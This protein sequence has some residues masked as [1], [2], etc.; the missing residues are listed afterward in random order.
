MWVEIELKC[1]AKDIGLNPSYKAEI[2]VEVDAQYENHYDDGD[3]YTE[4]E[5]REFSVCGLYLKHKLL[6]SFSNKKSYDDF[7]DNLQENQKSKVNLWIKEKIKEEKTISIISD[8]C[9]DMSVAHYES[10]YDR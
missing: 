6:D 9:A 5:I 1:D 4:I 8:I 3:G 7:W 2:I 10:M